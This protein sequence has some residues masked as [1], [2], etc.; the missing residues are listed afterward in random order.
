MEGDQGGLPGGGGLSIHAHTRSVTAAFTASLPHASP[1]VSTRESHRP[2]F[3]SFVCL[4]PLALHWGV[5]A[6]QLWCKGLVALQRL[7]S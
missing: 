2:L 6:F 1:S 4:A 5:W 3:V 7:G